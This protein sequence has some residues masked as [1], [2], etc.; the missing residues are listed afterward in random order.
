MSPNFSKTTFTTPPAVEDPPSDSAYGV[1]PRHG[2]SA[3][4]LTCLVPRRTRQKQALGLVRRTRAHVSLC[5]AAAFKRAM[6]L[7]EHA[8]GG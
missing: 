2:P 5:G 3:S 8:A 4:E 1:L 6:C 7:A